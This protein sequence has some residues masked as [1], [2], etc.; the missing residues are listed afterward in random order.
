MRALLAEYDYPIHRPAMSVRRESEAPVWRMQAHLEM[1][2]FVD[3]LLA[4]GHRREPRRVVLSLEDALSIVGT[5]R[6]QRCRAGRRREGV[7]GGQLG[8]HVDGRRVLRETDE[9]ETSETGW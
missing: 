3:M 8:I 5:L 6:V 1:V 2:G 4:L 7:R 9:P